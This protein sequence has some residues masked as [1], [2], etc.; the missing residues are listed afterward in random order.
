MAA[1]V[2][3]DDLVVH[4]GR[5]M[6]VNHLSLQIGEGERVALLGA[7]GAGKTTTLLAMT[8]GVAASSGTIKL[9]APLRAVGLSDQPPS[10]YEYLTITEHV[11]FVAETRGLAGGRATAEAVSSL[12]DRLG[13]TAYAERPCRELSFGLRQRVSLAAALI[14]DTQLLLL[15][16]SLNGLDPHA[17]RRA[18]DAIEAHASPERAMVFSTHMLEVAEAL[19][20]R[21]VMMQEGKVIADLS[22][23]AWKLTYGDLR[24]AY[25]AHVADGREREA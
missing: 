21:A 16:E 14:G 10:L 11:T 9:G 22:R 1:L 15:D 19:C 12:L 3:I 25:L 5:R 24:R 23:E 4:Y 13:L 17:M 18:S 8:G 20:T 7:N 2:A 6:A